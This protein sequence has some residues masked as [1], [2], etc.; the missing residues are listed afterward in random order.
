MAN[1]KRKFK[2]KLSSNFKRYCLRPFATERIYNPTEN[3]Y[4]FADPR[5]GSTW[6]MEIIQ[7]ITNE[8][9]IWE[10][11]DLNKKNNPFVSLNFDWRQFIPSYENWT[12]A[13][14][15][16][17]LLFK[18]EILAENILD[19]STFSQLNNSGSLLFKFC[20]GNAL[21]PWL[22]ENFQ[23][24]YKPIY[25][26]RH[27]FAVVSSQLRHGA[28]N[29]DLPQFEV[30][31]TSFNELYIEHKDFLKSIKSIEESLVARWCLH[32]VYALNHIENNKKWITIT[33]EDFVTNPKI[34]TKRI[35]ELWD[36]NYDI[37]SISFDK[38]SL[39]TH[40]D[41]PTSK[42]DKI[43]NWKIFFNES[44][45]IQMKNVLHHFEVRLYDS[46]SVYPKTHF[47]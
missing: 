27:P 46:D 33:Y 44:Q 11:L 12:E 10:P 38:N 19:Y 4:I 7:N 20:R 47:N 34:Q 25:F 43:S 3:H 21:L 6:L 28:W 39:T 37:D 23:F 14:H 2:H 45:I 22:V 9:V 36:M 17:E 1:F 30:P 26:I 15:T 13:K 41:S 42:I 24:K 8:P 18:G 31:Q 5:G 16:F 40:D 29:Y 35:L 32:N